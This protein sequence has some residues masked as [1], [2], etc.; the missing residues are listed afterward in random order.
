MSNTPSS[1]SQSPSSGSIIRS[2]L[3]S[4]VINGVLPY[5]LYILLSPHLPQ[6]TALA[7]TAVP[8]LI[9]TLIGFVLKRRIDLIGAIALITI[10]IGII[11]ALVIHDPRVFL[12]RESF[13]TAAYG[14]LCFVSLLFPRPLMF[15]FG[16]Y[17]VSG[18]DRA[19]MA[20][21]DALWQYPYFGFVNRMITII[22]GVGFLGEAVVRTI[23]V[24]NLSTAQFLAISPIVLYGITFGVIIITMLYSRHARQRGDEMR[25]QHQLALQEQTAQATQTT[26]ESHGETT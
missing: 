9:Y 7:I 22:W 1:F 15:Y 23:L 14:I 11:S 26:R 8:A 18:N 24:Y 2:L 3:P 6:V 17:F 4:I 13:F 12:I 21:Y 5:V 16:R 19:K 20:I 10:A 25:R